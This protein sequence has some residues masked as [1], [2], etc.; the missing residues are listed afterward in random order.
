MFCPTCGAG[1]QRGDAYCTRCGEWLV[2]MSG[3]RRGGHPRLRGAR[4]P[5]RRMRAMLVFNALDA[6]LAVA[7]AV[8]LFSARSERP[9]IFLAAAF[10][11]TIAVHQIV[12]LILNIKMQLRLK[13]ARAAAPAA[14]TQV[15]QID[16]SPPASQSPPELNP[17]D[18]SRFAG[19][20]SSVTDNTTELLEAVPL[21]T[22]QRPT[23]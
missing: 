8:M 18:A 9:L 16:V 7:A 3:G 10:C 6:A 21:R 5:E 2:E 11:L 12:S 13:R 14:F 23:R 22:E 4:T 15:E 20:R 1:N 17:A 19:I